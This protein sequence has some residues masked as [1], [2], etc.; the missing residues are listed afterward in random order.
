MPFADLHMHSSASDGTFEPAQIARIAAQANGLGAFSIT[1]HDCLAA[2]DVVAAACAGNDIEFVPGVEITTKHDGRAVHMLGYFVD[3]QSTVLVDYLDENRRRRAERVY[4]MADLLGERGY[5]VS[6]DDLRMAGETPNRPLLARMLVERGC[7]T[8]VDEA[9]RRL[10][11]SSSPFYVDVVYPD[12]L[13][14][15]RLITEAGGYAFVAHPARYRIVD[16]IGRFAREGMIGLEA[17]HTLQTPEQS[18]ELVKIAQD[19]GLGVSGGSD[20]HGDDVH[21]AQLGGCGLDE[22]QYY[23]FLTACG[24]A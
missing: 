21:R 14:A 15:I 5:P 19:F 10:L 20:W 1:D 16:L 11:G 22:G 7:V 3:P 9:F 18:A 24:R 12:S 17:Y 23:A 6:S 2:L 8:D 13:E 4:K